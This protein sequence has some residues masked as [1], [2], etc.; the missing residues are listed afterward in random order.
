MR[1]RVYPLRHRGRRLPWREV[2]NAPSF[3]GYLNTH[4]L[5]LRDAHYLAAKLV[6]P[7]DGLCKPLLPELY[8][9]V[10]T[11]VGNGVLVM[12]GF[13]RDRESAMVQE[14]RCELITRRRAGSR[15]NRCSA[16]CSV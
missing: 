14:W 12:R 2:V 4:Y 1:C 8:E 6:A 15:P 9:P 7:G 13:E 11:N 5:S 10:L 16:A 3:E